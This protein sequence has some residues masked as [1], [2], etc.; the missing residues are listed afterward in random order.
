MEVIGI[1][2]DSVE[3]DTIVI[4]QRVSIIIECLKMS[5]VITNKYQYYIIFININIRGNNNKC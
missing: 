5:S 1:C 3:Y 4:K 2:Y